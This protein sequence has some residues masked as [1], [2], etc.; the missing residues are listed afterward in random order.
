MKRMRR[1]WALWIS[2]LVVSTA[3][4]A[5]MA[6]ALLFSQNLRN[7]L[8]LWGEDIQMTVYLSSDLTPQ[9]QTEIEKTLREAA[10]VRQVQ[11]VTQ[12]KALED[13]RGELASYA[14]DLVKDDE[15]LKLIP[16]SYQ[17]SL[18]SGLP[19]EQ[20][21]ALLHSLAEQAKR[22]SG[23]DEVSY[24]QDWVEKYSR[25]VTVIQWM[26]QLLAIIILSASVFVMSNVIRALVQ[27]R[28]EEIEVLE[29]VGATSAMIR[30]PFLI[31][32][33]QMG[34]VAS[35]TALALCFVLFRGVRSLFFHQLSFLQ[36]GSS[37]QFLGPISMALFILA[38]AALGAL[39]SYLCVRKIN[40]GWAASQR[41]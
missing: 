4:F 37:L 23:V 33:A 10:H 26:V 30:R 34:L 38:G 11:L 14:P 29:L 5:V 7:V 27:S 39:G 15:L 8:T 31:Q 2:S 3:C 19:A 32:G 35:V 28:R 1:N 6:G 9:Q 17:V 40:D 16:S 24:G 25:F 20:Q 22:I 36:L 21:V 13:F 18:E 12:E 41:A